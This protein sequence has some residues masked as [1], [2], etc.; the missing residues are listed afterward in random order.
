MK[1][2]EHNVKCYPGPSVYDDSQFIRTDDRNRRIKRLSRTLIRKYLKAN[3]ADAQRRTIPEAFR[4]VEDIGRH[5]QQNYRPQR[6]YPGV[7]SL[8]RATYGPKELLEDEV[9]G[10]SSAS[11]LSFTSHQWQPTSHPPRRIK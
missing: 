9:S 5:A 4:Q 2:G 1:F 7:A 11:Q 3:L 6:P 8:F 10:W